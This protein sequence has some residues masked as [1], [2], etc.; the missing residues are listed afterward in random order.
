MHSPPHVQTLTDSA[1]L[2]RRCIGAV[3]DRVLASDVALVD[4]PGSSGWE[5]KYTVGEFGGEA[6]DEA[7]LTKRSVV[8]LLREVGYISA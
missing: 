4:A 7:G 8:A 1:T 6:Y 5:R 3:Y 2:H